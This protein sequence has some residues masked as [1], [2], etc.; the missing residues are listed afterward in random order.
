MVDT[1]VG[2]VKEVAAGAQKKVG[3]VKEDT[4]KVEREAARSQRRVGA[5]KEDTVKV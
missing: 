2:K 5:P 4:V 3:K 1:N